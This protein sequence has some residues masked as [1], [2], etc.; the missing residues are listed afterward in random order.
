MGDYDGCV[1]LKKSVYCSAGVPYV[2]WTGLCI[3]NS[4]NQDNIAESWAMVGAKRTID[5]GSIDL[6]LANMAVNEEYLDNY[7]AY[8]TGKTP[9]EIHK[10]ING[11]LTPL[12]L[13]FSAGTSHALTQSVL[14]WNTAERASWHCGDNSK[15]P[16]VVY[17][18]II[19][20]MIL[21]IINIICSLV[22]YKRN[23]EIEKNEKIIWSNL[24]IENVSQ[25]FSD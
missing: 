11:S 8:R 10:W 21:I 18:F 7:I 2:S 19:P 15:W 1:D 24:I 16:D 9:A 6:T 22:D 14:V 17:G 3:P 4:C 5:L 12:A 20:F 23:Y 13:S 25:L